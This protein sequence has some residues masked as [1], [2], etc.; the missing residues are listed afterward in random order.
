[1]EMFDIRKYL[2]QAGVRPSLVG[3]DYSRRVTPTNT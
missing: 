3:L 1:M 2:V